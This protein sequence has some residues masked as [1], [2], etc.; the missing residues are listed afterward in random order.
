MTPWQTKPVNLK[1]TFDIAESLRRLRNY[2]F[3]G[4]M[5]G[6]IL[7]NFNE[8]QPNNCGRVLILPVMK[9]LYKISLI[10]LYELIE[11]AELLQCFYWE[12]YHSFQC[13]WCYCRGKKI[14]HVWK[15]EVWCDS[16][17]YLSKS[18]LKCWTV[19][20]IVLINPES[21]WPWVTLMVWERQSLFVPMDPE[22]NVS[23][24]KIWLKAYAKA[25]QN[26]FIFILNLSILI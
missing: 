4:V 11:G 14:S 24:N 19:R 5:K 13:C 1:S 22:N 2:H 10:S 23:P 6:L 9:I 25:G 17:K 26:P 16:C 18:C 15:R 7:R 8:A 20:L 12:K 3:F 21:T